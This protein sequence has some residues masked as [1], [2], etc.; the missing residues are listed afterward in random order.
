MTTRGPPSARRPFAPTNLAAS[1]TTD[2]SATTAV[3]TTEASA[4]TP[5]TAA[6]VPGSASETD[7]CGAAS[8]PDGA[9]NVQ[10]IT[11]DIDG[12]DVDDAIT[13][14]AVDDEWRVHATSSVTG[15]ASDT[16]L[17]LALGE[18]IEV[19]TV[20]F[21]DVD[22]PAAV[23]VTAEGPNDL[24]I[25]AN[26]TFLTLNRDYCV[27]QWIYRNAEEVDEPFE[28]VALQEPGH[29]TGMICEGSAPPRTYRLVDSEQNADGT[30]R[31]V[32]RILTH[33]FTRAEISFPPDDT[34]ADS[35]DFAAALRLDRR[36]RL[37]RDAVRQSSQVSISSVTRSVNSSVPSSEGWMPSL[38]IPSSVA[39]SD[40]SAIVALPRSPRAAISAAL[41][42]AESSGS[43][44][45]YV[46][47]HA[48]GASPGIAAR[49]SLMTASYSS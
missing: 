32:N 2:A 14:Y 1:V 30:W 48:I 41:N 46:L 7:E 19:A 31:V 5:S 22:V 3:P 15:K 10:S 21:A 24:G 42:N 16:A 33:D 37:T 13:L 29:V 8:V 11:G 20:S 25:D 44:R 12:D 40:H 4:S 26:F 9:A 47:T 49:S 39:M 35:P 17:D 38:S 28:W 18:S 27:E 23:M 6:A 36:L 34:V 45:R 43:S